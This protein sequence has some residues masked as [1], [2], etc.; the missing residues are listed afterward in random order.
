MKF[1]YNLSVGECVLSFFMMMAVI[2]LGI[3]T[4]QYWLA[5]FGF[6]LFLRGLLGW[7]PL[8]SFLQNQRAAK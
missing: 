2:V 8:K 3:F 1:E 5:A 4:G 6:P 7:C